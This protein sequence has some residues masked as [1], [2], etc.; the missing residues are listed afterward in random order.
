M[1]MSTVHRFIGKPDD[2][3]WEN[4]PEKAYNVPGGPV[5]GALG[6]YPIS[7]QDG[8]DGVPPN[9]H[10]RY[11]HIAAGGCS[12]YDQHFHDHGVMILHGKARA[13]IDG[14]EFMLNPYDILY[15]APNEVHQLFAVGDEPMGFLCVIDPKARASEK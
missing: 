8:K 1:I 15:I 7:D 5:N 10:M 11:F 3:N 13:V 9:F 4:T 2:Y 6:R 14:N 12:A